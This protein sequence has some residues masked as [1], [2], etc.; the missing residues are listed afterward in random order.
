MI[1]ADEPTES[2]SVAAS[3]AEAAPA[4]SAEDAKKAAIAAAIARAKARQQSKPTD[5]EQPS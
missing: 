2:Q 3:N 5:P 1:S 4:V